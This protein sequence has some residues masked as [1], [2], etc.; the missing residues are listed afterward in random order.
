MRTL[1]RILWCRLFAQN[2]DSY[3]KALCSMAILQIVMGNF[4]QILHFRIFSVI[5]GNFREILVFVLTLGGQNK[6]FVFSNANQCKFLSVAIVFLGFP[7]TVRKSRLLDSNSIVYH[8]WTAR[9]QLASD[10]WLLNTRFTTIIDSSTDTQSRSVT[11]VTRPWAGCSRYALISA[12]VFVLLNPV[13][14]ELRE[15]FLNC[16]LVDTFWGVRD[17]LN[18]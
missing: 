13:I 4:S 1:N 15:Q 8:L 18:Q 17:E 6:F 10:L 7:I 11:H 12:R 14:T 9:E 2:E 5:S 3:C 16:R